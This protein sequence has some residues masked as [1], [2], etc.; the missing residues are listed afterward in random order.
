MTQHALNFIGDL[1]LAMIYATIACGVLGVIIW[2]VHQWP[3]AGEDEREIPAMWR[4][5]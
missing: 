3:L 5:R 2:A 4:R 1:M